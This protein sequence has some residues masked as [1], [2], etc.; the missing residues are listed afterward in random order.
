M[1]LVDGCFLCF[2]LFSPCQI[3]AFLPKKTNKINPSLIKKETVK[4]KSSIVFWVKSLP[5]SSYLPFCSVCFLFSKNWNKIHGRKWFLVHKIGLCFQE[6]AWTNPPKS[7]VSKIQ[8]SLSK[9]KEE[10][11]QNR[12][13]VCQKWKSP[14][15]GTFS[16]PKI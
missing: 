2:I 3:V 6:N 4:N 15:C 10:S 16:H 11:P 12:C 8:A 5:P 14:N 9:K 13:C 7:F 1:I